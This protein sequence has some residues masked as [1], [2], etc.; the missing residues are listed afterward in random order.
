M[1]SNSILDYLLCFW[2]LQQADP[3]T[4]AEQ[5]VFMT[6]L[7][8]FNR[9]NREQAYTVSNYQL[10]EM[11][12]ISTGSLHKIKKSLADKGYISY[13]A[14]KG[15]R[16]PTYN[17]LILEES[18]IVSSRLSSRVSSSLSSS[19]SS[20]VSSRQSSRVSSRVSSTSK[21]IRDKSKEIRDIYDRAPT[22]EE[23]KEYVK[24]HLLK[25]DAEKFYDHYNSLGWVNINGVPIRDWRATC[26][27]W[28]R[29]ND[30]AT[31]EELKK[32]KALEPHDADYMKKEDSGKYDYLFKDLQQEE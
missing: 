31:E 1:E 28:H 8:Y 9:N 11:S 29:K 10:S 23:V 19:L 3:L 32:L 14:G 4:P 26:R 5:A 15:K 7:Y 27:N 21:E 30:N 24:S 2:N 25:V 18:S 13:K 20:R 17:I 6:L 12:N 22:L 16:A